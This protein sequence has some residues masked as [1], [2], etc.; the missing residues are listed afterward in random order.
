M[1]LGGTWRPAATARVFVVGSANIDIVVRVGDLPTAGETVVGQDTVV[2]AGGKGLNQAV[3]AADR[4][5]E[6]TLI[7]NIGVDENAAIVLDALLDHRVDARQIGRTDEARTGLALVMVR[8]DGEN[9]VVVAPGANELLGVDHLGLLRDGDAVSGVLLTQ[10]EISHP[11]VM[12]AIR[13][14]HERGLCV[15]L[16]LAPATRLHSSV[17]ARVDVL[18]LNE[19]ESKVLLAGERDIPRTLAEAAR[20]IRRLGPRAVVLTAGAT[21]AYVATEDGVVHVPAIRVEAID[22]TGAGDAFTGVLAAELSDGRPL[23]AAV[24]SATRAAARTVQ[25][26]GAHPPRASQPSS[27]T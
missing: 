10:M 9:A 1:S 8:P 27:T 3:A 19:P 22:T 11:V 14:G 17:L 23:L 24:E 20:A 21:G 25:F 26:R 13:L 12:E 2:V 16:N 15:I 18:V 7:A 5:V 6:V 4:G